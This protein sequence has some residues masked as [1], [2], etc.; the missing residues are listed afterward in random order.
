MLGDTFRS[1]GRRNYRVWVWGALFSNIGTWM[2][3]TTQDWLVLTELT[4]HDAMAI[5]IVMA[6]QLAPPLLLMLWTGLLAG[7]V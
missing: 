3:F 2:Q 4:H 7:R 6:L 5:G 1:L